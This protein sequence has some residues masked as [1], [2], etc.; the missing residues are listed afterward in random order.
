MKR[1]LP[2]AAACALQFVC[3]PPAPASAGQPVTVDQG[4]SWSDTNRSQYY[5]VDQ[6]SQ[7]MPL[8]WFRALKRPDGTKFLADRLAKYGYLRNY[9]DQASDLPVGFTSSADGK[10]VGMNCAACHTREIAV[11]T[12]SYR[13]DGGPAISDF[14]GFLT[15][16]DAAVG[17]LLAEP[18]RLQSF[19]TDVLGGSPTDGQIDQLRA[20]VQAW[21]KPY[22]LIVRKGL[23][24]TN[25]W[26]PARLDAVGMIF[27]RLTG[28][29]IGPAPDY[30][31]GDN[32]RTADAP[33]RYPF[34]WNASRQDATQWPG[35]SANG[36][37]LAAL[38]R[39][40][41]EVF[42]VFARFHPSQDA[43]K[44]PLIKID[45]TSINSSDP[46]GLMKLENLIKQIGPPKWQWPT[47]PAL[48]AKG[49]TVF[50][51]HTVQ[52]GCADCHTNAPPALG[53]WHAPLDDV[54]TDN[55]EYVMLGVPGRADWPGWQAYTGLLNGAPTLG[56]DG[57]LQPIASSLAVLQT[58]V[59]GT[60]LE[61][62]G[63]PS[64]QAEVGRQS[65]L[66]AP[67]VDAQEARLQELT[68]VFR[69]PGP[70]DDAKPFKYEARVLYGV[71]AAAPY[72]H[73]G[74]VPTLADLL[75]PVSERPKS[76]KVG[77][78]YDPVKVGLAADQ[79]AFDYTLATTGCDG[80]QR[81]SGNSN[82]GHEYGTTLTPDQKRALLEYLKTL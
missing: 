4:L 76:F 39:N 59:I 77:P 80:D 31:I 60:I 53:T 44:F 19:A 75:N 27:D 62:G 17:Q 48:V 12:T 47:D 72:L 11:G 61:G 40:T 9:N 24:A 16:L 71:W 34:L 51:L 8:S 10:W 14:Q 82:C 26:G 57:P 69:G 22:D 79:T 50:N 29:D 15:D 42:G 38:G 74:S 55:R 54:G 2:V 32:V 18:A 52:G 6:G 28:L 81:T 73:N 41:G 64:D 25:P 49:Q 30:I 20:E 5:T 1:L 13:I 35:F 46:E 65:N 56:R 37:D 21:F 45:Y 58:A 23:P 3:A 68:T 63:T 43:K 33:V 36:N 78:A 67:G 70:A 66:A 7:L